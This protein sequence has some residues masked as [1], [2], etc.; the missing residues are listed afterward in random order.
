MESSSTSVASSE[1]PIALTLEQREWIAGLITSRVAEATSRVSDQPTASV[2]DLAAPGTSLPPTTSLTT[3]VSSGS[4]AGEY[5]A[6]CTELAMHV[7]S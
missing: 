1:A 2:V 7:H 5:C 6:P 3:A 4:G